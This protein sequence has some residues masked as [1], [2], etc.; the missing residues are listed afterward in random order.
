MDAKFAFIVLTK[1]THLPGSN[2]LFLNIKSPCT[3]EGFYTGDVK[4]H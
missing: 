1:V 4:S 3:D 2:L